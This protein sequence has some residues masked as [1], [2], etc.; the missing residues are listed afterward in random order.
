MIFV[1][2]FTDRRPRC[3]LIVL[4]CLLARPCAFAVNDSLTTEQQH[5]VLLGLIH[6]L[7]GDAASAQA[8]AR[9]LGAMGP[10]AEPAIPDLIQAC[11]RMM[12]PSLKRPATR[13]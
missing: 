7:Q 8:A 2:P 12:K 9:A 5:V 13:W 4:T 1:M 11:S 3:V 10:A 6:S